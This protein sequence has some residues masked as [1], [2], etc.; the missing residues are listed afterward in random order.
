MSK[1]LV[2]KLEDAKVRLNRHIKIVENLKGYI[3]KVE[4]LLC[5]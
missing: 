2:D 1:I 3:K 4:K 5:Q